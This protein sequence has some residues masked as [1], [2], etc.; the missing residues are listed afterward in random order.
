MPADVFEEHP[1][2]ADFSDDAGN[3]GPEMAGIVGAFALPGGAE[4]L[5][6]ITGENGVDGPG[7]WSPVECG[8][9]VP[10][11]GRGEVSCALGCDEHSSGQILPF[12]KTAGVETGLCEQ[13]AHI[14]SS[15]ACA[16]GESV[17]GTC[18]HVIL[19]HQA[20]G[21]RRHI[22]RRMIADRLRP[23]RPPCRR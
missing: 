17:A 13:E 5:A 22:Q 19:R 14:Q 15:A 3:V 10:D 4:W 1:S 12:D 23:R 18:C 21:S 2:R 20:R 11:R 6:G 9:V 8:E 16:E 7:E